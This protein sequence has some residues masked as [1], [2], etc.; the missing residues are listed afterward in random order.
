MEH[1]HHEEAAEQVKPKA[2]GF[3]L[4]LSDDTEVTYDIP[5]GFDADGNVNAAI[6]VVSKNSQ[7]YKDADR[8]LARTQLK[9]SSLRGRPLDFK[10]DADAEEFIDQREATN[11]ALAT[12]VTVGWFGLSNGGEDFP[13][14]PANVK[15]LYTKHVVVRDKVLASA[16]EQANFLKR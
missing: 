6:T 9:K 3:D 16:E 15:L 5:L 12:A 1:G 10:K 7:A 13:F 4:G 2:T 11:I 14:T 8:K